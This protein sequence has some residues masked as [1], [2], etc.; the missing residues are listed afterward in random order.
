MREGVWSLMSYYHYTQEIESL[1][2][3]MVMVETVYTYEVSTKVHA[4]YYCV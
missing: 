4:G 2:L 1:K 3:K